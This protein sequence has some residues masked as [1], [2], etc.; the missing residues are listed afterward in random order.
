MSSEVSANAFLLAKATAGLRRANLFLGSPQG[1]WKQSGSYI[2][3]LRPKT[4][5]IPETM[6]CRILMFRSAT[7]F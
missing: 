3:V 1:P 6:V 2:L 5:W 4:W 7:E